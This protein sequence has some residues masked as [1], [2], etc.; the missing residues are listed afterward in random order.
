MTETIKIIDPAGKPLAKE[1]ADDARWRL[2]DGV[3]LGAFY[4]GRIYPL[5]NTTQGW[6]IRLGGQSYAKKQCQAATSDAAPAVPPPRAQVTAA[7]PLRPGASVREIEG[8]WLTTDEQARMTRAAATTQHARVADELA[9]LRNELADARSARDTLA[10]QVKRLD[11]EMIALR[12]SLRDDRRL[13]KC[14]STN[15][16]LRGQ[17]T[18]AQ[19]LVATAQ[20]TA[21]QATAG[22]ASSEARVTALK[23]ELTQQRQA[24]TA[25]EQ[26][27][28]GALADTAKGARPEAWAWFQALLPVLWPRLQV[29]PESWQ[30]VAT[31]CTLIEP[32][33]RVLTALDGDD[34]AQSSYSITANGWREVQAHIATGR[35]DRLR[36]YWRPLPE[37]RVAVVLYYKQDDEGQQAFHRQLERGA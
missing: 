1:I 35:D 15:T 29:A 14:E 21:Q 31:H 3:S 17:L 2:P 9:H 32:L 11:A 18:H 33:I 6:V 16:D 13:H 8:A 5:V 26:R 22:Q 37:Q 28:K 24:M 12:Q 4:S 30:V 19:R 36:V 25:L 34:S 10:A 23:T 20:H 27:L 7:T